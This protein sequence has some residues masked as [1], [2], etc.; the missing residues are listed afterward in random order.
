[1]NGQVI[2]KNDDIR[3]AYDRIPIENIFIHQNTSLLIAG[4]RLYYKIYCID[5]ELKKL[6]SLSKI[7]YVELVGENNHQVFKHKIKLTSGLGYGDFFI[8]TSVPSGNY[9]ILGYTEWM[10]NFGKEVIFQSDLC[11]INPYQN[12]EKLIL[13]GSDTIELTKTNLQSTIQIASMKEGKGNN[14]PKFNLNKNSFATR[15]RASINFQGHLESGTYSI[16]VRKKELTSKFSIPISK[17]N[18]SVP[19]NK[20]NFKTGEIY[21]P[22]LRGELFYGSLISNDT[23]FSISGKKVALSIPG[24]NF[25]YQISTSNEKGDFYFNL[26]KNYNGTKALVHVLGE[27]KEAFQILMKQQSSIDLTGL[28]FTKLK[29]AQNTIDLIVQRSI[30]NQ[31]E[32]AYL[33]AKQDSIKSIKFITPFYQKLSQTYDLDDYTRFS[34]I[35]ETILEVVNGVWIKKNKKD[36]SI[37]Q[38]RGIDNPNVNFLPLLLVD[39]NLIQDHNDVMKISAYK[40][41]KIGVFKDKF[42]I[43]T[44]TYQGYI[45][46]ETY[47]GYSQNNISKN[48]AIN[49]N[50]LQPQPKKKYFNQSYGADRKMSHIPDYRYQLLWKPDLKLN[51]GEMNIEFFTSDITGD[52]EIS[53]E[54]FTNNGIPVSLREYITVE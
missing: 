13:Q 18:R 16:S 20:D 41:E 42:S 45:S 25:V 35:N 40:I 26:N 8:P 22:E 11:I 39:G 1:M 23:S 24:R 27:G 46:F 12:N 37:F 31:V 3:N 10:K 32:N 38:V 14:D 54:G 48:Y 2:L 29:I 5:P 49:I 17:T 47:D 43:G 33:N 21:L 52:F 30:Y 9:K 51:E 44:K 15:S 7:A 34:T 36:E 53:L 19:T 6:S 50:L 28:E 4:E